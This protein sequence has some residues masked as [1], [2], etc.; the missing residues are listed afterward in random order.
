MR[1]KGAHVH[2]EEEKGEIEDSDLNGIGLIENLKHNKCSTPRLEYGRN[3][4]HL[5]QNYIVYML[6]VQL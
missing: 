6:A 5:L 3:T 4:V 1:K 2:S